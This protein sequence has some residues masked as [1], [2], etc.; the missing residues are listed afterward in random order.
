MSSL[1]SQLMLAMSGT[2]AWDT[3]PKM[4][5]AA[6][7]FLGVPLHPADHASKTTMPRVEKVAV[8]CTRSEISRFPAR[9]VFAEGGG[10]G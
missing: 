9:A 10:G 1:K 7:R 3:A 8:E 4:E 6:S 5:G 2:S